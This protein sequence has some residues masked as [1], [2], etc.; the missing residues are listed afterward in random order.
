[1]LMYIN[2]QGERITRED[3]EEEDEDYVL[4]IERIIDRREVYGDRFY[5]VKWKGLD[6]KYNTWE[7]KRRMKS[8]EIMIEE[9]QR[10]CKVKEMKRELGEIRGKIRSLRKQEGSSKK[11]I[12]DSNMEVEMLINRRRKIEMQLQKFDIGEEIPKRYL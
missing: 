6:E 2:M 4:R 1:M 11:D 3:Y 10:E 12:V 5:F 9:F 7:P 8:V